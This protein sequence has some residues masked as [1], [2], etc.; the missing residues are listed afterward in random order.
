MAKK[1]SNHRITWAVSSTALLV[2]AAWSL[3]AHALNLG[4]LQVLS[5]LGDPLHAEVAV[6]DATAAELSGLQAQ[7]APAALFSQSGM[8][9]NPALQGATVSLQTREGL[10]F[11][12]VQGR[13][14]VK[15]TFLPQQTKSGLR[16]H[17]H[18]I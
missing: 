14:P 7:V 9:F 10:P 3:P 18:P 1:S 17:N 6:V 2:L 8:E 13:Q 4:R 15:D 5:G 11:L 16:G 12:V